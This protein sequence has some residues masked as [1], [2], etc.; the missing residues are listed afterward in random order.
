MSNSPSTS[1]PGTPKPTLA[2]RPLSP[3]H[4]QIKSG[5]VSHS[6]CGIGQAGSAPIPGSTCDEDPPT[7]TSTFELPPGT[8]ISECDL[9]F[10]YSAEDIH[11]VKIV[12]PVHEWSGVIS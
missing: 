9:V 7:A 8:R 1:D 4:H 2:V 5:A 10:L 6:A 12:C 11:P 3:S